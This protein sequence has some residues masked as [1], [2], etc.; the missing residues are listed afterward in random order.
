MLVGRQ[1][2]QRFS[3]SR[4]ALRNHRPHGW[5]SPSQRAGDSGGGLPK[6]WWGRAPAWDTAPHRGQPRTPSD[7]HG[8]T[9]RQD[10]NHAR[11]WGRAAAASWHGEIKG[12]LACGQPQSSPTNSTTSMHAALKRLPHTQRNSRGSRDP[13]SFPFLL[14]N[15]ICLQAFWKY[16]DNHRWSCSHTFPSSADSLLLQNSEAMTQNNVS[17]KNVRN[18]IVCPRSC[19][20]P[21]SDSA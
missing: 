15:R 5:K 12:A 1:T 21:L 13:Q 8:Q 19:L 16:S 3:C 6:I 10:T 11:S 14:I 2:Q 9:G 17:S 20:R 7:P 4:G 18:V